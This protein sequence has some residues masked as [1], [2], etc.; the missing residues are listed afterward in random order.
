[1]R[2]D[3]QLL[4]QSLIGIQQMSELLAVEGIDMVGPLPDELQNVNVT[5]AAIVTRA[6]EPGVA[7]EGLADLL[8]PGGESGASPDRVRSDRIPTPR[9]GGRG[10]DASPPSGGLQRPLKTGLRFSLKASSAS[11]VSS[12]SASAAVCVCS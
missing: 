9:P 6:R 12:V 11:F 5:A 10:V 4:L 3:S 7:G 1:M 2:R 8:N